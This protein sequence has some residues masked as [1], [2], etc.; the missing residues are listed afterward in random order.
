MLQSA[1]A[2]ILACFTNEDEI[3]RR[4]DKR[5][6]GSDSPHASTSISTSN[7]DDNEA[8]EKDEPVLYTNMRLWGSMWFEDDDSGVQRDLHERSI[9]RSELFL[10]EFVSSVGT[11][12]Y[13][14]LYP[15]TPPYTPIYPLTSPYT[16]LYPPSLRHLGGSGTRM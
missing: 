9:L 7:S 15:L 16:P 5:V 4:T 12:L 10:K 13:P 1:C 11:H 6:Q 8:E 2:P 14:L 3:I